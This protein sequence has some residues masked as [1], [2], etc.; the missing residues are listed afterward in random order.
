[1]E[2]EIK[3]N[4]KTKFIN[5]DVKIETVGKSAKE[6]LNALKKAEKI[7]NDNNGNITS[8]ES[9]PYSKG[10]KY[11]R[12]T[13]TLYNI[14]NFIFNKQNNTVELINSSKSANC[15]NFDIYVYSDDK[16][17]EMYYELMNEI[18]TANKNLEVFKKGIGFDFLQKIEEEIAIENEKIEAEKARK[19]AERQAKIDAGYVLV[20]NIA[21]FKNKVVIDA[22]FL[23]TKSEISKLSGLE[24]NQKQREFFKSFLEKNKIEISNE[25]LFWNCWTSI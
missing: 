8:F 25:K 18:K 20:D 6:K 4:T 17:Q 2:T 9:L 16:L 5:F 21:E 10:G 15:P 19:L 23:K 11:A 14:T 13:S 1:M 24:K 7:I 12:H 3:I 22:D